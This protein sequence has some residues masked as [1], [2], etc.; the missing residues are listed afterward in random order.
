MGSKRDYQEA[1][2]LFDGAL[3]G[4]RGL[5]LRVEHFLEQ[6]D[7]AGFRD[8]HGHPLEN[9]AALIELARAVKNKSA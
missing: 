5:E 3:V 4:W 9:N 6:I 2:A 1:M 8:K 7:G